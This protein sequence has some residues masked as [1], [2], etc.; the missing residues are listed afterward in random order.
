MVYPEGLRI[1]AR[2]VFIAASPDPRNTVHTQTRNQAFEV[3]K[4]FAK[5]FPKKLKN[6]NLTQLEAWVQNEIT[7]W[8]YL[9][10]AFF[11]FFLFIIFYLAL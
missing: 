8:R 3:Y 6:K 4:Q 11:F 5:K 1:A 9:I 7:I 2:A 10:L